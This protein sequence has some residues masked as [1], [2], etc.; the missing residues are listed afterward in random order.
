MADRKSLEDLVAV[1]IV[2]IAEV[3]SRLAIRTIEKRFGL[4]NTDLRLMNLLDG[5]QGVT[6]NEIARRAHIDKAWVSRSLRELE[7]S[8]LLTRRTHGPDSRVRMVTLSAKGR[9]LLERV[10][11]LAAAHERRLLGGLNEASFKM[12]LERLLQ[13]ADAMLERE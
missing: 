7:S 6:V 8:G 5:K 11:P 4:R 1:R 2:R 3:I 12:Q 9:A 13:N 10:R